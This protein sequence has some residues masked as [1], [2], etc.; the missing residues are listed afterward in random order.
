[1]LPRLS[2]LALVAAC[3][4]E[5]LEVLAIEPAAGSVMGGTRVTL[6]G[7]GFTGDTTVAIGG[8]PCTSLARVSSQF[9]TCT[10]GPTDFV[11]GAMD[12]VVHRDGEARTLPAAYAYACPW[13]TST[14]RRS[15]G[16]VP[17]GRI[18]EQPVAAWV[19]RFEGAHGF[20][21]NDDGAGASSMADSSDV[22]IG[23]RSV[24]VETDGAGTERTLTRHGLPAIDF[25][26]HAVKVW[27]KVE[28]LRAA[29]VLELLLGDRGL[30]NHYRF[31]LRSTQVQQWITD[32]DW[33]A[34]SMSWATD[35]SASVVGAPDRAAI[36][37]VAFRVID[38]GSGQRVRLRVNALALV[39]EPVDQYPRGAV[40]ISFDD[41]HATMLDPGA[42]E[43][44]RHGWAATAYVIAESVG[45]RER[46]SLDDLHALQA[47]GWDIAAH[48]FSAAN[49]RARLT[50]L[51]AAAVEDDFVDMRAWLLANQFA[52][53]DH[54]AYPGGEFDSPDGMTNA[55]ALAAR[56]FTSCRTIFRLQREAFPPADPHKLRV[57]YVTSATTL[58]AARLAIDQAQANRE[59][60]IF[61]FH[62][63]VAAT[64][65][66]STEWPVRDYRALLD[67]IAASGMPVAT[68]SDVLAGAARRDAR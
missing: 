64:P 16:A 11:E 38:D 61:V 57:F 5:P 34:F 46:A 19:T 33:V 24:F 52:G 14:G 37:D 3:A 51:P 62:R 41:N 36:T 29:R 47:R 30:A 50:T 60:I 20:V 1:M 68:V 31:R 15:C 40:S 7:A 59:W 10:T 63:V 2:V 53:Y 44:D 48:A 21:A 22:A 28:H 8:V 65:S 9:L 27:L 54:C 4:S 49:H 6:V 12:V 25:T 42:V 18:A 35:G 56:Y 66:Q 45:E 67:H 13:T 39:P 32:G 55:A 43:L 58:A 23:T 26:G 17:P